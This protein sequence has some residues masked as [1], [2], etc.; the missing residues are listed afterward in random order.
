M[1]RDAATVSS[2]ARFR[3]ARP[4][5]ADAITEL[6]VR[7]KRHWGYSDELIALMTPVLTFQA[8]DLERPWDHVEVLEVDG[9]LVGVFRLRRR[10]E[11][12]FLEDLWIDPVAMGQGYGRQVFERAATVARSW[13]KGVMEW[14]SDPLAEPFYLHL[15]AQRV[16][17]S[18]A[19]V[20]PGRSIPLMRYALWS[21]PE[22]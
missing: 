5:E 4:D 3:R 6:I 16:A 8:A 18:P 21:A 13:G 19:T 12:A 20:I 9:R 14:E 2:S 17:M 10:T 22:H 11:L 15:G 1:T 7:S